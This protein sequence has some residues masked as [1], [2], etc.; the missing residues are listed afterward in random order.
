MRSCIASLV[1]CLP[2]LD[3][4]GGTLIGHLR[5]RNWF[6]KY[7]NNPYGVGYYEYAINANA[8]NVSS[9]GASAA[10]DVFGAF[11]SQSLPA[12]RYTVASWDVWWR[13]AFAFDV[14]VP[15]TG[16]SSDA[17][18]RLS[19]TMWGY[20]AFWDDAGYHEFG[21][22]F[23]ATGPVTMIY[24]RAPYGTTYTLSVR[25]NGPG[26]GRLSGSVD[27]TFSG[28]GDHRLIYGYGEMPTRAGQTYYV[29][30]RTSSPTVG[31]VVRQMDPRPD[32]S[33][34]MP[35]GCLWLGNGTSMIPYPDRDLGLIIMSDDD[36]LITNLYTR[37]SGGTLSGSSIGQ[38]FRAR[39]VSLVCA[40]V[41]LADPS[42]PTYVVRVLQGG[43]GGMQI[44]TTKRGKP[45]RRTADP[46]M[47]VTW[48]PGECPLTPGQ[49]YYLEITRDGGGTFNLAYANISNPYADGQAFQNGIA[50]AGTDLA[51]SL[52][53]EAA[54]GAAA[55][56]PIQITTGPI[57]AESQRRTNTLWIYWVTDVP[58]DSLVEYA[59]EHPPY[60]MS[61]YQPTLTTTHLVKLTNLQP[62]TLH[63]LRASSRTNGYRAAISHDFVAVTKPMTP[64]LL[65]NPSFEDG[66]GPSPRATIPGW[67]KGGGVDIKTSDG[68]WFW[69][70][71]PTNGLWL[72]EGAV[73]AGTS[74]GYVYQ[75]VTGITPGK[76]YMFSAWA[77]T[78][79]RENGTWKY[80]VWNDPNRL[81]YMRLGLD[82]TGGINPSASTVQWTPRFS[83]HLRYTHLGKSVRATTASL[84]VFVHMKGDG[85]EWHLYALDDCALTEAE[86]PLQFGSPR[87]SLDGRFETVLTGKANR[88][89]L[90]ELTSDLAN[91][92]PLTNVFNPTGTLPVVDEVTTGPR[93]R[94]YRARYAR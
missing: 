75:R 65:V 9:L 47:L 29:R 24:L 2:A 60:A 22:T 63:H 44:G 67:T 62:H 17:D 5:D 91:W 33:D 50:Q 10:T 41:W 7:Q 26:S 21:Q 59:A 54:P 20:P 14:T 51:G 58:S 82:P 35:G 13:P 93:Q 16:L 69:G 40:A 12:G 84:T 32:F 37:Q 87:L 78:A 74:D 4:A 43:P 53:E 83:S 1:L 28:A 90:L 48:A 42:A 11:T 46:E 89:N 68:T 30:I 86:I 81:N 23:E 52:M 49:T 15:A 38:T 34:P 31:G 18:L 77:M 92:E 56:Q 27:R 25:T 66:T 45:A 73:N 64:N 85:L 80:D 3:A 55:Q 19:A 39:G 6:A 71:E 8:T 61:L 57:Q 70:L 79:P 72:L 88:T 36:G 94:F 76:E